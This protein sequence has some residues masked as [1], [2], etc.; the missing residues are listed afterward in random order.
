MSHDGAGGRTRTKRPTRLGARARAL[1]HLLLVIPFAA[2]L[3]VPLYARE[4]PVLLG[5]PFFY[6]YQFVIGVITIVLMAIVYSV[7]R[8]SECDETPES[9]ERDVR[10]R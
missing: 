6:W 10:A 2:L 7:T 5:W 4:E 8:A 3:S 1:V 9:P